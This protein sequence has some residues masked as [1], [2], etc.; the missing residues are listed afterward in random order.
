VERLTEA[1]FSAE[2]MARIHGPV[3]LDIGAQ[4][5]AEIAISIMAEITSRLRKA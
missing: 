2:Q 5:P 4:G 3:G 1:G